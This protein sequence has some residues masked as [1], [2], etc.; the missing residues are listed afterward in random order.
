M[1]EGLI[2]SW[3]T[4]N[5]ADWRL[6]FDQDYR[7]N[8]KSIGIICFGVMVDRDK[9]KEKWRLRREAAVTNYGSSGSSG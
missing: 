3:E 2:G 6:S 7:D 8:G 1:G 5:G 4:G 9:T